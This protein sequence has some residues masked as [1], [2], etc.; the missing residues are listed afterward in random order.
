MHMPRD[1]ICVS[2]GARGARREDERA[3]CES[4]MAADGSP[5]SDARHVGPAS[6]RHV[7]RT[8]TMWP[9]ADDVADGRCCRQR[10]CR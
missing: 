5:G 8:T 1:A 2:A 6:K 10:R 4:M 9:M 7:A 3:R